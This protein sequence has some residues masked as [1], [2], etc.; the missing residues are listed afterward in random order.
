MGDPQIT[1]FAKDGKPRIPGMAATVRLWFLACRTRPV[2]SGI[3]FEFFS[4]NHQF[5]EAF[6]FSGLRSLPTQQ[7]DGFGQCA[8]NGDEDALS[9]VALDELSRTGLSCA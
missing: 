8:L 7:P 9:D 2:L 6:S 3:N 1:D 5:F 4:L